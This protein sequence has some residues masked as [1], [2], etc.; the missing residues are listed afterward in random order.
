MD[1]SSHRVEPLTRLNQI[2]DDGRRSWG[3]IFHSETGGESNLIAVGSTFLQK[4]DGAGD[5]NV[6][7]GSPHEDD[8]RAWVDM[9][10]IR[11]ENLA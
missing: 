7:Y 8:N 6:L 9:L 1:S 11:V 5:L 4:H 2:T 3:D 10:W